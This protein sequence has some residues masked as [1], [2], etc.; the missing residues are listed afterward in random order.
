[1]LAGLALKRKW[2]N[3]RVLYDKPNIVTGANVQVNHKK[4]QKKKKK[5]K[6]KSCFL[7]SFSIK[8]LLH[9]SLVSF[10]FLIYTKKIIKNC[11]LLYILFYY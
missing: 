2:Q 3:K 9:V 11:I 1:M 4:Q 10:K 7:L 5:K 6:L 8:Q